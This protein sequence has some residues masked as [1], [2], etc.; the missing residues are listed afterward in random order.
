ML[1]PTDT[2]MLDFLDSLT[3]NYTGKV[4]LRMSQSRR[5]WRLHES[6]RTAA[7]SNVRVAIKRFMTLNECAK[8]R[9]GEIHR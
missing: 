8:V 5:G 2:E 3:G 1:M 6:S 9:Q 7:V 4:V